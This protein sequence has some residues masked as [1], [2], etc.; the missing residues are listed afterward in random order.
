MNIWNWS[1][2]NE[3]IYNDVK[4]CNKTRKRP[5]ASSYPD[6]PTYFC[7]PSS[8]CS[9]WLHIGDVPAEVLELLFG[10]SERHYL[11]GH[12]RGWIVR[13]HLG[14]VLCPLLW[15]VENKDIIVQTLVL[16]VWQSLDQLNLHRSCAFT[17]QQ[18]TLLLELRGSNFTTFSNPTKRHKSLK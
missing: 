11:G 2:W 17:W 16:H 4:Q 13:R 7:H 9:L 3:A 15:L 10:G 5:S 14:T 12:T 1:V 8:V 6:N 18:Q